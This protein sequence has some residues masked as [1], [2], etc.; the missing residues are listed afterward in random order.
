MA[1]P[2]AAQIEALYVEAENGGLTR[3]DVDVIAGPIIGTLLGGRQ[4]EKL[5]D[6]R[7]G[8][9]MDEI[10][11]QVRAEVAKRRSTSTGG[12]RAEH[13]ATP[14]QVNYILD[15]LAQRQRSGEGGGFF[16]GPTDR[17]GIERLTIDEASTY[18]TSLKG[19]Y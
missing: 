5:V 4:A 12:Q 18:I 10:A 6:V 3:A 11:D 7:S 15:L 19:D 14:R 9:Q 8:R 1:R 13:R 2:A 17:G 16:Q